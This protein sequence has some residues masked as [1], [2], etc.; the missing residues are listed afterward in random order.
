MTRTI[1][2]AASIAALV[3]S[4]PAVVAQNYPNRPISFI[5]GFAP[6]GPSDVMSRVIT[7][8]M[9]D[10]LKQPFVIENRPGAGGSIAGASVARAAPDGYTILL[11]TNGVMATNKHLYK[12][13]GYDPEKDFE[14]ISVLGT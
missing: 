11:A 13:I 7:R 14:P 6:G 4:A 1:A 9:E 10:I 5:I 8:K 3:Y 2:L 12:N